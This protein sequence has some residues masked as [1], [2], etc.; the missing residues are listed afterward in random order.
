MVMVEKR[1]PSLEQLEVTDAAAGE[2]RGCREARD[3]AANDEEATVVLR[4]LQAVK[5]TRGNCRRSGVDGRGQS[6]GHGVAVSPEPFVS[7][8]HLL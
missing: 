7:Q 6:G 8:I 1:D 4:V 3:A 2:V 5:P